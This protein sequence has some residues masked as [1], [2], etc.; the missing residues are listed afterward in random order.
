LELT[1]RRAATALRS[2]WPL[3]RLEIIANGHVIRGMLEADREGRSTVEAEQSF[4]TMAWVAARCFEHAGQT[5]RFAHATDLRQ[6]GHAGPAVD[7]AR[8]FLDWIDREIAF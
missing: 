4:P 1:D 2:P 3:G 5:I 8:F 7:D 6:C